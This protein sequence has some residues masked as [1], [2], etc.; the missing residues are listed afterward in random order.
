[1]R[2]MWV[3]A[4]AAV[5]KQTEINVE[6]RKEEIPNEGSEVVERAYTAYK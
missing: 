5:G 6:G 1:M 3:S 2:P 4:R